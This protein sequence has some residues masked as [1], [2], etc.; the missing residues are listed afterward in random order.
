MKYLK[1]FENVHFKKYAITQ[2]NDNTKSILKILDVV[3]HQ[4][5]IKVQKIYS[6]DNSFG[7]NSL[8]KYKSNNISHDISIKKVFEPTVIIQS[9]DLEEL[10]DYMN[11]IIDSKKYNL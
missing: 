4:D 11:A 8:V 9:D 2:L 6:L 1:T 3:P 7:D 5:S 10:I